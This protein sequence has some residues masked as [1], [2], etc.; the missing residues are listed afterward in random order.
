MV[1]RLGR[2]YVADR[3]GAAHLIEG[4]AVVAHDLA[5]LGDV[6]EFLGQLQYR[7]LPLGVLGECS[8]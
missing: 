8:F 4:V 2:G 3:E 1:A 7:D 6:T 5:G